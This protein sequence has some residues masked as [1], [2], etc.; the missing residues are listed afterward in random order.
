MTDYDCI[1]IHN[2]KDKIYKRILL[3][4]DYEAIARQR[5]TIKI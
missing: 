2:Y 1:I 5:Y 4:D 3:T